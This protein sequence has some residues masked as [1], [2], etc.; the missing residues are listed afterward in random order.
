MPIQTSTI[1]NFDRKMAT[2]EVIKY[3]LYTSNFKGELT[4]KP[5][6]SCENK[7][8]YSFLF[9]SSLCYVALSLFHLIDKTKGTLIAS[10]LY[11]FI[12]SIPTVHSCEVSEYRIT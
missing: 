2:L 9:M 3:D 7:K 11:L 8:I 4:N 6:V 10:L 12:R 1:D 5:I